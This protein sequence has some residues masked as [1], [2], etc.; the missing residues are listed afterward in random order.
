MLTAQIIRYQT[1]PKMCAAKARAS[2]E[3]ASDW[4]RI[5]D[6]W[7]FLAQTVMTMPIVATEVE[8][9][10]PTGP[11]VERRPADVISNAV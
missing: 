3:N 2:S 8:K 6:I 10:T 11:Q 7:D 1:S 5:A 4:G 9:Q